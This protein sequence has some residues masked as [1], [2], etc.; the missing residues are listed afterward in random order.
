[1]I[2]ENGEGVGGEGARRH[3]HHEG[4]ELARDLVHVRDHQEKALGGCERGGQRTGLQSAV[5]GPRR[6]AL[7][8]HLR[9]FGDEAPDVALPVGRPLVGQL[10][11]RGGGRDRV[12]GDH[13]AQPVS[14]GGRGFVAVDR[15]GALGGHACLTPLALPAAGCA[16]LTRGL[17]GP[18]TGSG[19]AR[20]SSAGRGRA[21]LAGVPRPRPPSTRDPSGAWLAG[22]VGERKRRRRK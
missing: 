14:D 4:R 19:R 7:R 13:L 15:D 21:F 1:V 11:H 20:F 9:D 10:A 6:P 2:A 5:H 16:P 22:G 8:L 18:W 17:G 3:V 12:D